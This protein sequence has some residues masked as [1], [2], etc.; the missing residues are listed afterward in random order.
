MVKSIALDDLLVNRL[1]SSPAAP[2]LRQLIELFT[3]ISADEPQ[4]YTLRPP[5]PRSLI[6]LYGPPPRSPRDALEAWEDEVCWISKSVGKNSFDYLFSGGHSLLLGN[7]IKF[8]LPYALSI[9]LSDSSF[10]LPSLLAIHS[11]L[12]KLS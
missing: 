6:T 5:N 8:L 9:S 3:N 2:F 1:T 10:V 12:N 7:N 11:M 4:V